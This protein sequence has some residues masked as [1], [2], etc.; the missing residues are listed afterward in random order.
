MDYRG[1]MK[2]TNHFKVLAETEPYYV[3]KSNIS[4]SGVFARHPIPKGAKIGVAVTDGAEQITFMGSQINHQ[5]NC[6]A[7][8]VETEAQGCDLIAIKEIAQGEEIT[9]NYKDTPWYIDKN[10]EGYVEL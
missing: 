2:L 10:T 6:N 8:L 4:G 9:A 3:G 7:K 5:L 1:L